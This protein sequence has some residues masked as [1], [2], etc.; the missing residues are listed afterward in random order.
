MPEPTRPAKL[1]NR[2]RFELA[3]RIRMVRMNNETH[4][5]AGARTPNESGGG[6]ICPLSNRWIACG[7]C[8]NVSDCLVDGSI[9]RWKGRASD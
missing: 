7:A 1:Q 8:S 9:S 3:P 6:P 2:G 4:G 5:I